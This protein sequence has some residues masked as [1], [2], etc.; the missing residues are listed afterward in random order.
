MLARRI[1]IAGPGSFTVP[2]AFEDDVGPWLMLYNGSDADGP[3]AI[4]AATSA[5]GATWTPDAGN[6][7]LEAVAASQ[8]D[9]HVKDPYL[10]WDG[11]QFVVY[12]SG[13]DGSTY[14]IFRATASDIAG[15]WTVDTTPVIDLGSSGAFDDAHVS[16][17]SVLYEPADTG[18]EW[19]LWYS[20]VKASD[21]AVRVG[22][23][24]SSDGETFTKHGMVVDL[25]AGGTWNEDTVGPAT[26]RNIDGT[27]Y[28]FLH[29]WSPAAKT[30]GLATFTDPEGTYTPDAGNP[31]IENTAVSRTLMA[32][33]SAGGTVVTLDSSAG[34]H[35]NE[36]VILADSNSVIENAV[37]AS[38]DT[39]TQVTL[40][41][42]TTAAFTVSQGAVLRSFMFYG[43]GVRTLRR[44][45]GEWVLYG[46][47]FQPVEDLTVS[48]SKLREGNIRLT[49]SAITGPWSY[50]FTTGELFPLYP[51]DTGWAAVSAE[52]LSVIPEPE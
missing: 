33:R 50:D 6:P 48:G 39:G 19:K 35:V 20:A 3:Y 34:L 1:L 9:D 32:D 47:P 18:R 26:V 46:S 21:G 42:P 52:N 30:V 29:G 11:S 25:G 37:I 31:I 2:P 10:V 7:V 38:I 12:F 44:I 23:A 14:R 28:L 17:P 36:P 24:Y 49:A 4:G 51:H 16:Y 22:Y 43:I 13:N 41:A 40:A 8:L 15:P 5:D 27:Y 45:A